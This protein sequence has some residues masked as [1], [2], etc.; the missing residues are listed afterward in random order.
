MGTW[1]S[2]L[3]LED[4]SPLNAPIIRLVLMQVWSVIAAL[5]PRECLWV[6]AT[7][8]F[9]LPP[10]R[11][12][13]PQFWHLPILRYKEKRRRQRRRRALILNQLLAGG[14]HVVFSSKN[15]LRQ[16]Y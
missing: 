15:S 1:T 8:H 3:T 2:L 9:R 12:L 5:P 14:G 6:A 7:L 10:L 16:R 4:A 13:P 11:L